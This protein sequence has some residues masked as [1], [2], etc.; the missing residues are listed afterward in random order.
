[1][2]KVDLDSALSTLLV[3]GGE[4]I[5]LRKPYSRYDHGRSNNVL[6]L[7]VRDGRIA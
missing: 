6:K 7:K 1:M 4:G 3:D 5:M 2:S